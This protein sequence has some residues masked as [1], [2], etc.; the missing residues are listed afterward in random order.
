M[1]LA[2]TNIEEFWDKTDKLLFLSEAC[3][4]YDRKN[5]WSKLDH[6]DAPAF[7]NDCTTV[8]TALSYCTETYEDA[9][10]ALTAKLNELHAIDMDVRYY[11]LILGPWLLYF[12]HQTYAKYYSLRQIKNT[13]PN[14]KTFTL[15]E[16]QYYTPLDYVD[17]LAKSADADQYA[18][19]IYSELAEQMGF[20]FEKRKLTAPLSQVSRYK[21]NSG[22][23]D[24]AYI[25]LAKVTGQLNRLF[26]KKSITITEPYF[27]YNRTSNYLKLYLSAPFL[28]IFDEMRYPIDITFELDKKVRADTQLNLSGDEFRQILSRL[29]IRELPV[30]YLEGFD[31]FRAEVASC[32]IRKTDIFYTANALSGNNNIARFFT[33]GNKR[34]TKILIHQH[35]GTFGTDKI[36]ATE[37]SEIASADVYFTWGWEQSFKTKYLPHPNLNKKMPRRHQ[38]NPL[39]TI[40]T[41]TAT[42][43]HLRLFHFSPNPSTFAAQYLQDTVLF[44]KTISRNIHVTIRDL[45]ITHGG[46]GWM[47]RQRLS[48]MAGDAS[49]T[50]DTLANDF[51]YT[52]ARNDIYVSDHISTTYL[53]ALAQNKPTIVFVNKKVCCFREMALPFFAQLEKAKILHYSPV[54]A[55]E[56]LNSLRGAALDEWWFSKAVQDARRAFIHEHARADAFWE[57]TWTSKFLNLLQMPDTR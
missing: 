41:R 2:T 5:V 42:P 30:I 40:L 1:F 48:D 44:L 45:A 29:L 52:L 54:S 33:A 22:P 11:R 55:A 56:H 9:L 37:E 24:V 35:G 14:I 26:S 31:K 12:I 19:Q 13:V 49:F 57:K 23:K 27:L 4:M 43:R 6:A 21:I 47:E 8:E 53:E 46:Y 25:T 18:L 3:K 39:K 20:V 15:D 10:V 28:Y 16:Q 38:G 7:W 36:H 32:G 17:Y 51:G 34:T 50:F